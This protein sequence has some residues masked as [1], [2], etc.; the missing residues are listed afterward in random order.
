M[1]HECEP[2][3][4]VSLIPHAAGLALITAAGFVLWSAGDA[5]VGVLHDDSFFYTVIARNASNGLGFT[6]DGLN[7]T[8]GFHPLWAVVLTGIQ[9]VMPFHETFGVQLLAAIH[10]LLYTLGMILF[11]QLFAPAERRGLAAILFTICFVSL[12]AFSDFGQESPLQLLMLGLTFWLVRRL[13]RTGEGAVQGWELAALAFA[14]I[15]LVTARLDSLVILGFMCL[16]LLWERRWVAAFAAGIAGAAAAAGM[17]LWNLEM[18]GYPMTISSFLKSGFSLSNL[19]QFT[20]PGLAVRALVVLLPLAAVAADSANEPSD[21]RIAATL[22]AGQTTYFFLLMSYVAAVGSWYFNAPL[23]L[24]LF[25]FFSSN[26]AS[27]LASGSVI[28][29]GALIVVSATLA[30]ASIANFGSKIVGPSKI[31][32]VEMGRHIRNVLPESGKV[33]YQIDGSGIVS[34]Y[35]EANIVNGDGLVNNFHY[36]EMI[37][38][39]RICDYIAEMQIRYVVTDLAP[40]AAGF[41]RDF[42]PSFASPTGR[43]FPVFAVDYGVRLAEFESTDRSMILSIYEASDAD[44]ACTGAGSSSAL[45][46]APAH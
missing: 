35:G 2:T 10:L 7:P 27:R 9:F 33:L 26:T 46:R 45:T 32:H 39:G 12:C 3:G 20:S 4:P 28:R 24:S 14:S 1:A 40:D 41:I 44:F 5:I 42:I 18:T 13:L 16:L 19:E 34:Y 36:Q 25:V 37:R 22:L 17:A 31:A 21:R 8:N 11:L 15:G 6:F 38:A 29:R 30:I 43:P 23:A